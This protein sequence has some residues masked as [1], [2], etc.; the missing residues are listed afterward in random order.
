MKNKFLQRLVS[1]GNS[2]AFL[3]LRLAVGI[4]F[5][6]HGSQKLFGWFGGNGLE[7]TGGFF[8]EA[9]GLSPGIFW[10]FSAGAAEFLGG[11]LLFFGLLTRLGA[12]LIA[13]VMVT[14]ILLVHR[15][16][17]FVNEGGMEFALTLLAAALAL[18][19]GGG[20]ALSL[21]RFLNRNRHSA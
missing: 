15:D 13:I 10:A 20:G 11:I 9:I 5:V 19:I 8:E 18:L 16:A 17:F 12:L 6:A 14:A 21:D 7:G 2:L 4:V 1:T 3:P